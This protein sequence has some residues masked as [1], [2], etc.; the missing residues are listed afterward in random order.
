[1]TNPYMAN[2]NIVNRYMARMTA[3]LG[4]I[5]RSSNTK[6]SKLEIITHFRSKME[7]S[8]MGNPHREN[9][10]REMKLW[11]TRRLSYIDYLTMSAKP[12]FSPTVFE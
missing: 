12:I 6:S 2:P 4:Q 10:L 8:H 5:F 9:P 1:M 3:G 7:N 11:P